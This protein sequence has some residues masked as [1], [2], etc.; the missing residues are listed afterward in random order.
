MNDALH[1]RVDATH[2]Y[3]VSLGT[4]NGTT[5]SFAQDGKIERVRKDGTG[6][7]TLVSSLS[8]PYDLLLEGDNVIFSETGLAS[9]PV[10][11]GIRSVPKSGGSITHLQDTH[12]AGDLVERSTELVF[13]GQ[14]ATSETIGLFRMPKS[15][16]TVTLLVDDED[17]S[18]GPRIVENQVYYAVDEDRILR[19]PVTGGSPVT[20]VVNELWQSG[21]FE[22]DSCGLYFGTLDGQLMKAPR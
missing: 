6:R 3:W 15:G 14:D 12:L 20:V 1:V 17:I 16:G 4:Y 10:K 22:V 21:D 18:G 11:F 8:A 13:Y 5:D 2:V 19:V 7:E 9:G